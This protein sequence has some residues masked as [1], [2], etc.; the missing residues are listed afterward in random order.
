MPA[1]EPGGT[2][3]A[4]KVASDHHEIRQSDLCLIEIRQLLGGLR[5]FVDYWTADR[6]PGCPIYGGGTFLLLP[7]EGL[8]VRDRNGWPPLPSHIL[9][10]EHAAD[11][12]FVGSIAQSMSKQSA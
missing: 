11:L 4:L 5:P 7:G 2:S 8:R 1:V 6:T 9:S 12:K 3:S 10:I